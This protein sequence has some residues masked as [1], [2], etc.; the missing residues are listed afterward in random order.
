MFAAGKP[1]TSTSA[2][3]GIADERQQAFA[4]P[5]VTGAGAAG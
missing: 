4:G 1:A 2:K 3:V 5:Q